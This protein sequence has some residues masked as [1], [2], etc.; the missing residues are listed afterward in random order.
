VTA[1][2]HDNV[3][4]RLPEHLLGTL[5]GPDD[6]EVRRHLRGCASCRAEMAKLG[7]GISAFAAAAHDREPP[8]ELRDR[9]LGALDDEWRD[10]PVELERSRW[11]RPWLAAAAA[12]LAFVLAFTWGIGQQRRA[13][14]AEVD[15]ASYNTLLHILGGKDFRVGQ[16]KPTGAQPV[17]GSVVLYDSMEDQSWGLVTVRAAGMTGSLDVTLT[18]ASGD[19]IK[20]HPVELS[21]SGDGT[22]WLVT[23]QDISLYNHV[24]ISYGGSSIATA[25]IT[26][27]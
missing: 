21:D 15:A 22:S 8:E 7:E 26:S 12:F 11:A 18:D 16:L 13:T 25:A 24:E 6:L 27:A 14:S 3:R 5:E 2:T 19:A 9:V 23:A 4:E 1:V 17:D 10:A 20:L